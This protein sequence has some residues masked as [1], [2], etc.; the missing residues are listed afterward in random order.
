MA[1]SHLTRYLDPSRQLEEAERV[2]AD[3]Q[4]AL[5]QWVHTT[6]GNDGQLAYAQ[7]LKVLEGSVLMARKEVKA[8]RKLCGLTDPTEVKHGKCKRRNR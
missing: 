1:V 6:W 5:D 7:K 8:A 2:L 4:A 3:A